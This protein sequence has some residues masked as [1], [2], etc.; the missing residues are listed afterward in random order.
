MEVSG[1]RGAVTAGGPRAE[2]QRRR[3]RAS[4]LPVPA[5]AARPSLG[6]EEPRVSVEPHHPGR[7]PAGPAV[8]EGM[9][10][11]VSCGTSGGARSAG[12]PRS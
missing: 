11:A 12:G 3:R 6:G 2:G 10:R 9:W 1:E 5:A 8:A 4:R 7:L